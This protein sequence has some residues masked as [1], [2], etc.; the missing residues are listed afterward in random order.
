LWTVV[1]AQ[2]NGQPEGRGRQPAGTPEV[3]VPVKVLAGSTHPEH[4]Q[5]KSF[6]F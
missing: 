5:L 1:S 2:P 3:S 4:D 6:G